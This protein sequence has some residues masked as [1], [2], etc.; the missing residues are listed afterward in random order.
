MRNMYN[1]VVSDQS[2]IIITAHSVE[3]ASRNGQ[4]IILFQCDCTAVRSQ[5]GWPQSVN[6]SFKNSIISDYSSLFS[7]FFQLSRG[8]P[9]LTNKQTLS[10]NTRFSNWKSKKFNFHSTRPNASVWLS[11]FYV[12]T[13]WHFHALY[14]FQA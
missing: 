4:V 2:S 1:Y 3:D 13:F 5:N 11:S 10:K 7:G 8:R 9:P 14:L 12:G 6:N